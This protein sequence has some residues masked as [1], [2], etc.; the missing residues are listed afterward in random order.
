MSGVG[1]RLI[2][3]TLDDLDSWKELAGLA[4]QLFVP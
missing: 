1:A 4:C 3:P 2:G